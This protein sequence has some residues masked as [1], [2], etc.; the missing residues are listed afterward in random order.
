MKL[1]RYPVY[2]TENAQIYQFGVSYS[3]W[4]KEP[5]IG[6]NSYLLFF[7]NLICGFDLGELQIGRLLF[8]ENRV[9]TYKKWLPF[10]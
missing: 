4:E 1:S 2:H 3:K 10:T 6:K 5:A 7:G 8:I 9:T